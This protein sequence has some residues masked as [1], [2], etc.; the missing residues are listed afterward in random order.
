M[1]SLSPF[2]GFPFIEVVQA[3]APN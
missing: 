1:L 3:A 2:Y